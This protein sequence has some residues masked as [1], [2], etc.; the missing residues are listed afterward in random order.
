[1]NTNKMPS[2]RA[3]TIKEGDLYAIVKMPVIAGMEKDILTG[4]YISMG[5]RIIGYKY[6]KLIYDS[7]AKDC[8]IGRQYLYFK[9]LQTN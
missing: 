2:V 8:Q 1:M 3:K 7:P 6:W 5:L 4:K 9:A